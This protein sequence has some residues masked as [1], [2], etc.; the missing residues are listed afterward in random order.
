MYLRARYY[1][2]GLG[3]F[4]S[5]DPVE[6]GNRYGYV[7]GD[8]VNRVDP[9]GE[10]WWKNNLTPPIL[11][12]NPAGQADI[13]EWLSTAIQ[14]SEGSTTLP[15]AR[16]THAE[17]P[18]N[19]I[20]P[21]NNRMDLLF[22]SESQVLMYEIKSLAQWRNS[23]SHIRNQRINIDRLVQDG[24]SHATYKGNQAVSTAWDYPSFQYN[25]NQMIWVWG[26]GAVRDKVLLAPAEGGGYWYYGEHRTRDGLILY[27]FEDE[28]DENNQQESYARVVSIVPKAV[29]DA[30]KDKNRANSRKSDPPGLV[31]DDGGNVI[32]DPRWSPSRQKAA[33]GT[34]P[35]FPIFPCPFPIPV[36]SPVLGPILVPV[37]P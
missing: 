2:P 18:I 36:T 29:S 4:P 8:V 20:H 27:W 14:L 25:W 32:F 26:R 1:V 31:I 16:F 21:D 33:F 13:G 17:Y 35:F 24:R 30:M 11:S 34:M 3:V 37:F 5:L 22:V 23:A 19:R 15:A 6:E 10:Y 12:P 28:K 9:S 7:G